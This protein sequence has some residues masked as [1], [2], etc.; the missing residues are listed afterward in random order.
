KEIH[1]FEVKPA[2]DPTLFYD[3]AIR[4]PQAIPGNI[5]EYFH[6]EFQFRFVW[7]GKTSGPYDAWHLDYVYLNRRVN[8]NEEVIDGALTIN[9]GDKN[10]NI[11]DRAVT[12]PLSTILA[13][14]YYAMPYSHF[15]KDVENSL[16]TPT[17]HLFNLIDAGF[18]QVSNYT[19]YFTITHYTAGTPSVTFDGTVET[20]GSIAALPSRQHAVRPVHALPDI[21]GFNVPADSA[22]VFVKINVN[23]GDMDDEIDYFAR[24]EPINFLLNDS[25]SRTFTLSDYY[26]YDDGVAEYAMALEKQGN[27]FAYRFVLDDDVTQ[28]TLNGLHIYFP[29]AGGPAPQTLQI[30]VFP[31]KAG[32]PD[33]MWVYR[34]TIP[35]TRTANNRFTEISFTEGIIVRDTFYIGYLE[36]ETGQAERVRIGLDASHDTGHHM[37]YRNTVYH[38]WLL[39]DQLEGSAMIR[40]RFGTAPIITGVEG[41]E[42]NPVSIYPNPARDVF[43]MKG[44]VNH[45][46]VFTLTGQP[47]TITVEQ[48][49]DT[50][51]IM[52]SGAAPGLYLVRYRA[53]SSI[54]TGKL[55]VKE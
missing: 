26:A 15:L 14:G 5:P 52:L 9:E 43:Y 10:T 12:R 7:F 23:S 31:D 47:V 38:Q 33:S 22:T 35:V 54:Y 28:D 27:Q 50:K 4:I 42:R 55:L 25:V 17:L 29:F 37:Y 44:P 46:Q 2:T 40:P 49:P 3:T 1:K 16:V 20:V 39:N 19:S 8:D 48:M 13:Q 21:A 32:K 45:V 30:F 6:D 51:K 11:S 41:G 34:Q 36:T 53:G 24:Y 18:P